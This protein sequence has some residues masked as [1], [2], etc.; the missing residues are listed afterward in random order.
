MIKQFEYPK[1]NKVEN[2]K[3]KNS[4]NKFK[5]SLL[6]FFEIIGMYLILKVAIPFSIQ[7]RDT[8]LALSPLNSPTLVILGIII[9]L[10]SLYFKWDIIMDFHYYSPLLKLIFEF[11]GRIFLIV[12]GSLFGIIYLQTWLLNWKETLT[13][14]IGPLILFSIFLLYKDLEKISNFFSKC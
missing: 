10:T 14:I 12:M 8:G 1:N 5:W 9:F 7:V 6:T 4:K 11:I 13:L 3:I 2:N